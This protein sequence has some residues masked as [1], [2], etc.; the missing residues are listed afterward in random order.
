MELSTLL[1]RLGM[2]DKTLQDFIVTGVSNASTDVQ[3]GFIFVPLKGE[4]KDGA[5]FIDEAVQKGAKLIVADRDLKALVPVLKVDDARKYL[6]LLSAQFYPSQKIKKLAITGTNGKTSIAY[7]V[8][9]LLNKCDIKTASIGT[10][11]VYQDD[12]LQKGSMTTPDAVSLSKILHTL[13]EDGVEV[14]VMEASSHGLDQK[15][16][17]AHSFQG[18]GFSN[19]TRDHLDYHQ[20][21]QNYF[22][23][24]SKLFSEG[25]SETGLAVLNADEPQFELL[26]EIS[27]KQ[28]KK[29]LSY[30][31]AGSD[32]KIEQLEALPDGQNLIF[33]YKDKKYSVKLN[34]FGAFQ[35]FNILCALGL[36]SSVGVE[37]EEMIPHLS[38]LAAPDGRLELVSSFNK[39]NI[40]VDYAHTPDALQNVLTSLRPHTKGRLICVVG[41]GGNRDAGKRLI[42]GSVADKEADV[43]YV[44]DDNP[45]F[46]DGALIRKAIVDACPKAI[47]V[48]DRRKAIYKAIQELKEGDTLVVCGKGHESGQTVNGVVYPFYDK[49][50]ILRAVNVLLDKPIWDSLSLKDALKITVD[51]NLFV[52]GISIDTR[53]L[54]P[55]D[56][57]IAFKGENQDG[58][59]YV[60]MAVEKG[61]SACLVEHEVE[62]VQKNRQIV[63]PSTLK[64]LEEM[65]LYARKRSGAHFIAVTGS[66]GKTTTKEMLKTVLETQGVVGAT[67]GNFNNELGVPITLASLPVDAKYAVIELGMNHK[68]EISKLTQLVKPDVSVITMIGTAHHEFFASQKEIALAKAEI[69]EGQQEGAVAVLNKSDAFFETLLEKAKEKNLK[70]ITYGHTFEADFYLKDFKISDK[71]FVD[72][73]YGEKDYCYEINY[74]GK[75]FAM[76]SLAVLAVVS[77]F[78]IPLN[79]VLEK[80]KTSSPIKGRGL[81]QKMKLKNGVVATIIDDCYNANPSSMIASLNVLGKQQAKR[82]VAILGQMLELGDQSVQMHKDLYK[83]ILENNV[84][85]VYTIGSLMQYLYELLPVDVKGGHFEKV[86]DF[87]KELPSVIA[88]NDVVLVKGSNSVGLR[89]VVD[90]FQVV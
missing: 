5:D 77:A 9:Q 58:H 62:G 41:C 50:E 57:F 10:L 17:F 31:Y 65:A 80:I 14:A 53:T 40:F 69:F 48:A 12:K 4:K 35:A 85:K 63:V 8:Y 19:L 16:L 37:V 74:L 70:V 75:H 46:E 49:S 82:R 22:E 68:G 81:M 25:L 28:N 13:E 83:F 88:E 47:E 64:A 44:T 1:T 89:K 72:M 51:D 56:L 11:G 23:A 79:S 90:V 45:R 61:A 32:L 29:V 18:A 66:S 6:S 2:S 30:G 3:E 78:N 60:H 86:D 21:M 76:N 84:D 67:K 54:R 24:K 73:V 39:A 20:T 27:K 43:V 7:F 42:M 34:I 87:I 55:G 33:W 36:A 26:S 71:C 38:S 52:S 59:K 15:R